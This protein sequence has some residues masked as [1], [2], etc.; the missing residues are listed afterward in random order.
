[1]SKFSLSD[2]ERIHALLQAHHA[3]AQAGLLRRLGSIDLAEEAM[4][5]ASVRALTHWPE[6]G[7]PDNV[8]A[9]LVTAGFNASIDQY[10]RN[11]RMH[12]GVDG[13]EQIS[14]SNSE[15]L[16]A[17]NVPQ[18]NSSL[19]DDD[20]L[21]LIFM[22]SHPALA[23]ENQLALTLKLVMGF[24][25]LEIAKALLLSEKTLE[26]RLTRTKRKIQQSGIS[27]ELS[28]NAD[29]PSRVKAVRQVLYLIFNEGYYSSTG[30][31]LVNSTLCRQAILMTRS[32]C[33]QFP[34]PESLG[35][36][37]LML[38]QSAREKARIDDHHRLITLDKQDRSQ[39][40]QPQIIE[41]DVLLQKALRR[42]ELGRYQLQAAI[43]GI[44]SLSPSAEAT[45]WTEITG[46][47]KR[48]LGL[49][50]NP[51]IE[52]NYG[53]ALMMA[54]S[55]QQGGEKI[56]KLDKSLANYAPYYAALAYYYE[57]TNDIERAISALKHAA[58]LSGS[59]QEKRHYQIQLGGL[60]V[61]HS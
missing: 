39:W 40:N 34:D 6:K 10:R 61:I 19:V 3:A 20:V 29:I 24:S 7:I 37:A 17:L 54:G 13:L 41:A 46:L 26:Q 22:C 27:F 8:T 14:A 36:L 9:W 2:V 32:L 31:E 38:F 51:V 44:H 23:V 47:Y 59:E 42:A 25:R 55:L 15:V 1:M 12:T 49:Q 57:H 21:N 45:D 35:L 56:L 11:K 53:V 30:A 60:N 48:L 16:A 18:A 5:E 58:D 52:L 33:R 28:Q 50:P 43:A 4:Q